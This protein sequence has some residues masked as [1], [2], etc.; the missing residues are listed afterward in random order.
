M[1]RYKIMSGLMALVAVFLVYLGFKNLKLELDLRPSQANIDAPLES[2]ADWDDDGLNNREESF[3]GSDPNNPDSDGDEYLDGEEVISGHDPLIPGPDDLLPTNENLTMKMSQLALAG[4]VEGSLKSNN[5]DYEQSLSDL[6]DIIADDAISGFE[7][8]LSETELKVINADEFSQQNYIEE[9]SQ[10]YEKL[11]K[12]FIEQ[13]FTLENNLNNIGAYGM[14][15]E[16]VTKSFSSSASQYKEIYDK[17]LKINVPK[18][19]ASNHL[20]V[21]KLTGELFQANQAVISGGNDPIKAV[22]GLNKIVQLWEVLP[23]VTE[24]YSKK[25]QLNGL[26]PDQTIFK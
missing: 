8:D 11:L 2:D 1:D 21:I 4:L 26:R 25:I 7:T 10:V 12:T 22:V 17:L 24:S 13:M 9:F 14:A 3:W 19:W 23:G 16:G 18:N 6:A 15:H 20:G 5:S